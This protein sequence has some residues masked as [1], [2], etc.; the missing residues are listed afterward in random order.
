MIQFI[1]TKKD[2]IAAKLSGKLVE[3]NLKTIHERIHQII[4]KGYKVDF[5][6][7]MEDFKDYSFKGFWEDIKSYA[8]HNDN[9]GKIAFVGN[10][11][12]QEWAAKTYFFT[13]SE[14]KYF[15][16]NNEQAMA[17]ATA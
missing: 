16:T 5:F 1:N 10:K 12:W 2:L 9:Y 14:A 4:D 13:G 11:K 17:W 15:L 6:F 7:V 3:G 8:S